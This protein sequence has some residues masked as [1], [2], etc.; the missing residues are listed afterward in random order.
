MTPGITVSS[1]P[2]FSGRKN[3]LDSFVIVQAFNLITNLND[4]SNSL[5]KSINE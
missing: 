4:Y 5:N 3:I 1:R 2:S